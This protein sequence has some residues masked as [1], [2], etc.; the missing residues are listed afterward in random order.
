MKYRTAVAVIATADV[1]ST[2]DYYARVLDFRE[3]FVF[4][5]PP[6]YAGIE[7]DGVL[8]YVSLDKDLA[9]TL[10]KLD[11]HPE[12]FLWVND[13]DKVF[14]EHK[15]RRR[16]SWKTSPIVRGTHDNT[17]SQIPTGT[18][19]KLQSLPMIDH[20]MTLSML[21]VMTIG[22]L[23]RSGDAE[24][25]KKD[26][27]RFEGV[28]R[29]ALVEVEG[30]KQPDVSFAAHK[31]IIA[32]DGDFV[33][34][35][36][37]KVTRGKFKLDPTKSPKY[38]EQ[39]ITHGPAK[40][41]AFSCIYEIDGDT[42]KLCGSF[43]GGPPPAVFETKPGSGLIFQVLARTKQSV[44]D[45]LIEVERRELE[46]TWQAV[47]YALDG[48]QASSEDMAKIKLS[49]D[50]D[51]RATA[52]RDGQPFIAAATMLDPT[53]NPMNI[54]FTYS[55]GD[56]KGKTAPGI[57]KIEDDLLT[58]CRSCT[59]PGPAGQVRLKAR[60]RSDAHDLQARESPVR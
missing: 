20:N 54:D 12:V 39:T 22:L 8:L 11:L 27:A 7:R 28:W 18:T 59:G 6:V 51:G 60:Q 9:S 36:G 47:S 52:V 44:K 25:A 3:H 19:S 50:A 4:G 38:Y 35:Q 58:I 21:L 37:P 42:Y 14:H 49:I 41:R 57:Y 29:I 55:L 46:G 16:R 48:N 15:S 5:D 32:T 2:I 17:S 34:V 45:A 13:V 24:P 33:V 43:R 30:V 53:T 56:L 31:V 1:R 10:E 40:G 23:T 26:L